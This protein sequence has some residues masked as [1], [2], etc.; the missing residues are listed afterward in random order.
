M[1]FWK[2][3]SVVSKKNTEVLPETSERLA[4]V[5]ASAEEM[6]QTSTILFKSYPQHMNSSQKQI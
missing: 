4:S 6:I 1:H 3:L 5:L 2:W